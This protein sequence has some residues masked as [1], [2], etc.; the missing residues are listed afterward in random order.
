MLVSVLLDADGMAKITE[1]PPAYLSVVWTLLVGGTTLGF[2]KCKRS[3]CRGIRK[4]ASVPKMGSL[5]GVEGWSRALRSS[6][7]CF[8]VLEIF[9]GNE[10][11]ANWPMVLTR[12]RESG[13]QFS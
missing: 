10:K 7:R 12:G 3:F 8:S 2:S 9:G 4:A 5:C 13:V 1:T 6:R 11:E